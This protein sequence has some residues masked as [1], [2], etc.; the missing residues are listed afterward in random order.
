MAMMGL[1]HNGIKYIDIQKPGSAVEKTDGVCAMT[2]TSKRI[3]STNLHLFDQ[4]RRI[5][6][7]NSGCAGK[8]P[9]R[10]NESAAATPARRSGAAIQTITAKQQHV[11]FCLFFLSD[12]APPREIGFCIFRLWHRCSRPFVV[13]GKKRSQKPALIHV[14]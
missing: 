13:T 1:I 4:S 9:R 2:L 7:T 5:D 12:S 3:D 14:Q 11:F 10:R 8:C 6:E